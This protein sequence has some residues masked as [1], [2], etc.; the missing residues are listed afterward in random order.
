[1]QAL[2]WELWEG[3]QGEEGVQK[4]GAG[5]PEFLSPFSH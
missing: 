3:V 5:G 1:M 4:Q 2:G